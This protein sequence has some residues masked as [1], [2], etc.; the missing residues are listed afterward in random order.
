MSNRIKVMKFGGTSVATPEA[1]L[2]SAQRVISAKEQGFRPVVVVSAIGRKGAP[3]A[4]D[5]LM[6]Y[7]L[8]SR[9][10]S[11]DYQPGWA[12]LM[13]TV[14]FLGG[15]QLIAVGIIGEYLA[16]LS[17]NVRARPLYILAED[18]TVTTFTP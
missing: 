4:T 14:L 15:V 17:D 7:T 2:T 16:R 10:V 18:S 12:S 8:Y 11:N 3:Y 5:T 1:R 6:L 13:M 9:F